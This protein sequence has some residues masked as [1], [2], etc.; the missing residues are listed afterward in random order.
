MVSIHYENDDKSGSE[1]FVF[2]DE[3][4]GDVFKAE[5]ATLKREYDKIGPITTDAVART[6][7]EWLQCW[8]VLLNEHGELPRDVNGRQKKATDSL[9]EWRSATRGKKITAKAV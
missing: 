9:E 5:M 2:E 7:R 4:T 3:K 1:S 6:V 8:E